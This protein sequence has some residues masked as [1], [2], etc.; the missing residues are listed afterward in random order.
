MCNIELVANPS[1]EIS[2]LFKLFLQ[3]NEVVT[4]YH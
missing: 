3:I 2:A 4:S 1:D